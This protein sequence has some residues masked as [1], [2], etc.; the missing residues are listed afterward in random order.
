MTPRVVLTDRAWPDTDIERSVLETAGIELVVGPAVAGTAC[1]IAALLERHDPFAVMSCW[2]PVSAAAVRAPSD[3][4][5][6]ARLGVGL[7]NIAV[8]AATARG[9][10]VTNVPDYCVEEVS[11]H[12]I[13][14]LLSHFR[15]VAGLDRETKSLRWTPANAKLERIR[16]LTIGIVGFGR[17]GRA[18]ARKLGAFGCTVLVFNGSPTGEGAGADPGVEH[19]SLAAMSE[20]ADAIVLHAPLV[21]G[22][23]GLVDDA[24]IAGCRRRPLLVNVSRGGLVDNAALLRGLESGAL[25][26]AALDVIDGEPT[27]PTEILVH[28]AVIA[29]PHVAFLSAASLAEL[30]RRAAEEVVRVF[31]GRTPLHPCNRP[32]GP[33]VPVPAAFDQGVASDIRVVKGSDGPYVLKR[34]LS[35]LRVA[36]EWRSDPARSLVEAAALRAM[37]GI[38]GQA[39]VPRVLWTD[40]ARHEFGMELVPPRLRNW[41]QELMAGRVD[42]ATASRAGQLL[43]RLHFRSAG[44]ADLREQFGS[45]QYFEELRIRPYFRRVA[46][47][48]PDLAGEIDAVVAGMAAVGEALVHG[49]FSPKNILADGSDVVLLDCEVAHWGDPR[50]DLAFCLTHLALKSLRRSAPAAALAA[51]GASLLRS[52]RETGPAIV[53]AALVRILGCLMLARLEGD[54]PV[55]YLSDLD[56][57]ATKS[58][59]VQLLLDPEARSRPGAPILEILP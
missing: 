8:D 12:A 2:A 40:P 5:I 53:D 43:G 7:D 9:A 55:D 21:D 57:A 41:K 15:G 50:F 37:A 51:A 28:P 52:Y 30:R 36:A 34:A 31:D 29:T 38:I 19:V 54:S 4:K 42:F 18:T 33:V 35:R 46:E 17:T 59:A 20:R 39:A 10:W 48:N 13:A 11:D 16:D 22:T 32:R 58:L 6:V 25:R 56:A 26:G 3:L 27:P 1:E 44:R 47:R 14:L 45:R 23:R 24:F 49:D